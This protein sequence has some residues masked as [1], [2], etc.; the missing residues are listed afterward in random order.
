MALKPVPLNCSN[1][2]FRAPLYNAPCGCTFKT[3]P[4]WGISFCSHD[5]F[6]NSSAALPVRWYTRENM[7]ILLERKSDHWIP[8]QN[9]VY[10]SPLSLTDHAAP[11]NFSS[12]WQ[13]NSYEVHLLSSWIDIVWFRYTL[14]PTTFPKVSVFFYFTN[15][16]FLLSIC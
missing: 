13:F 16:S 2:I 10:T 5:L 4:F 9:I 6:H 8:R 7:S 3:P 1:S 15:I 12:T 14:A 11:L